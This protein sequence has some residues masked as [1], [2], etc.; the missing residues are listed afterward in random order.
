MLVSETLSNQMCCN[1]AVAT[2]AL[3]D[4]GDDLF[5]AVSGGHAIETPAQSV[6]SDPALFAAGRSNPNAGLR[7]AVVDQQSPLGFEFGDVAVSNGGG[8]ERVHDNEIFVSQN[9]FGSNPDQGCCGANDSCCCNV[10][11]DIAFGSRVE[12][13]LSQKQGVKGKS[14]IAKNKIALRAVNR[15]F[16]HSSIISGTPA[17]GKGK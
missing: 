15:E 8:S 1:S 5:V 16:L 7:F 9:Q 3:A 13:G 2:H 17:V 6:V 10:E 12:N 4:A 11:T 14:N